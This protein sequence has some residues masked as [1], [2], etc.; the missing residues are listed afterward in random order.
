MKKKISLILPEIKKILKLPDKEERLN[1]LFYDIH[2][3]DVF[4]LVEG[5]DPD[6]IAQIIIALGIPNGIEVFEEFK[7]R[8]KK[9]IFDHFTR[10][11]MADVLEE[12]SPDE[13]V[14]FIKDLPKEVAEDILPLVAQAERN[15]I[16]KLLQYKEE[17]AGSILTTE[18][19]SLPPDITVKEALEKLR[20]QAFDRETIYY[21]YVINQE[22]RLLGFVSLK[23]ILVAKANRLIQDIMHTDVISVN[24]DEDKEI[25]AKKLSDYDFLA[26]PVINGENKLVGIVTVD[27]VVDIVLEEDTEDMLHYGAAGRH[28]DYMG[29]GP[30][31]TARQRILWLLVLVVAGFFSGWIMEKYAFQLQAV[32]ALTFFIPLLMDTGGNAGTQSSTVIIRGLATGEVKMKDLLKVFKKEFFTGL[33]IGVIMGVLA[34]ARAL[35]MQRDPSLG[36]TVGI[37]MV[38]T[39]ML[40]TSLG[41]ILPLLFKKL[42]LDPAL[43]SAPFIT[44]IVDIVTIFIYLRIA[45]FVFR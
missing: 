4:I 5:L 29:S 20:F 12:M 18:Y 40:A 44:S 33:L 14:D 15:D 26:I 36:I 22:R 24:V 25:V 30:F 45:I 23:D 21:I 37:A 35:I 3:R 34:T 42:K 27:D 13:R 43:M 1:K 28:I 6:K 38:A 11:W 9:R 31:R 10:E 41:A 2:P 16:K 19:A 39:V 32:V 17:T 8:D 7:I